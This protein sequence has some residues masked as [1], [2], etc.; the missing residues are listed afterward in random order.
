MT[1]F[2]T[3]YS[4]TSTQVAVLPWCYDAEIGIANSLHST[5]S[6]MKGLVWVRTS[7]CLAIKKKCTAFSCPFLAKP[8]PFLFILH[9]Y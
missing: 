4:S 5:A 7:K 2:L 3:L 1:Y 6:I 9:M 8:H